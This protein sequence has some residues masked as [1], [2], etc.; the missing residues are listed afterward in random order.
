M[1]LYTIRFLVNGKKYRYSTYD[2]KMIK[3]IQKRCKVLT[4]ASFDYN[5]L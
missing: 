2:F 3:K 4:I 5:E 1:R